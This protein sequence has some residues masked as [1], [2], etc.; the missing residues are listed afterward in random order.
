[1][2]QILPLPEESDI[3]TQMLL[4]SEESDI[5]TQILPL[6]EESDIRT[7]MLC[8]KIKGID[9]FTLGTFLLWFKSNAP[10]YFN[11]K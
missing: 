2:T 7:Q 6:P 4:L 9:N 5:K 3:R 8:I 10:V 1:M 11:W